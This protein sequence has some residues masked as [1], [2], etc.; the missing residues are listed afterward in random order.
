MDNN[1]QKD[2][3]LLWERALIDIALCFDRQGAQWLKNNTR[4]IDLSDEL[5]VVAVPDESA[6]RSLNGPLAKNVS[7]AAAAVV[8]LS[9]AIE[10]RIDEE[11]FRHRR[12][13][14]SRPR[15]D[16]VEQARREAEQNEVAEVNVVTLNPLI[17]FVSIPHY[18][19]RFWLP[20]LGA[21][22]FN[23]WF[24][25]RSYGFFVRHS[26]SDWPSV[27]TLVDTVGRPATRANILGRAAAA[28]RASQDGALQ[29]LIDCR[30]AKHAE[31]G[32]GR[33]IRHHFEVIDD[34]PLL[35]PAQVALLTTR[36]QE[37]HAE[38]LGYFKGFD[39]ETWQKVTSST[40]IGKW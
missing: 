22:P 12:T 7:N 18:A 27:A 6:Y 21:L 33:N 36:K 3:V 23:L 4:G 37:E 1:R 2:A 11:A 19:I 14:G 15:D 10:F 28:N 25:L 17:P 39:L 31:V 20:Y 29:V 32:R 16:P 40:L 24:A 9:R 34:L 8:G 30:I 26:G 5:I 35:A 13:V 38:F